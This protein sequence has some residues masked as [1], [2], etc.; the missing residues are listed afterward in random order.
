MAAATSMTFRVFVSSTF[1]DLL[2]ERNALQNDALKRLRT[3]CEQHGGRFSPVDLRW[4]VS[5]EAGQDQR[6]MSICL[7]EI[8]RCQQATPRPNFIILLGQRYGWR[9]L[10]AA[11]SVEDVER[12]RTTDALEKGRALFDRLYSAIDLNAVPN[13]H[14]LRPRT[15]DIE[16]EWAQIEEDVLHILEETGKELEWPF[17]KRVLYG[18]SATEQEIACGLLRDELQRTAREH[19]HAFFINA[20]K[21]ARDPR[22]STATEDVRPAGADLR[23]GALKQRLRDTLGTNVHEYERT[24]SDGGG[25]EHLARLCDDVYA[26]LAGTIRIEA[27]RLGRYDLLEREIEMHQRFALERSQIFIGRSD[28]LSRVDSSLKDGN[29]H[30]FALIGPSGSGKSAVMAKAFTNAQRAYGADAVVVARFIGFTAESASGVALL[31]SLSRHIARE[32]AAPAP[33]AYAE[34]PRMSAVFRDSLKLASSDRPLIIF[35]DALDQLPTSDAARNLSWLPL[36]TLPEHVHVVVSASSDSPGPARLLEEKCSES[37]RAR[38]QPMPIEEAGDLLTLWLADAHRDLQSRQRTALMSAF[39]VSGL[40]LY[41]RFAFEQCRLWRSFDEPQLLA[42][43][44]LAII[45]ALFARLGDPVNHGHMLVRRSLGYL[46]AAKEGLTEDEMV[47]VLSADSCVMGDFKTRFPKSPQVNQLPMVVWSR[48]YYDLKPY[49]T[50]RGAKGA[51]V[52]NFFH[53]QMREVATSEYLDPAAKIARH[54]A[55]AQYF[56]SKP[57]AFGGNVYNTRKLSELPYQQRKSGMWDDLE[58]TLCNLSFI[59]AKCAAGLIY[60]LLADYDAATLTPELPDGAK[61]RIAAFAQFV[62]AQAHL[63]STHPHLTFQQALNEPDAAAPAQSA[64]ARADVDKR[65]R[66]R[67]IGK[68]QQTSACVLTLYGHTS[69]VNGCDVSRDGRRIA[70][71]SSD[72]E[73]KIWSTASGKEELSLRGLP[74]SEESCQFSRDGTRV[75]SGTRD[76]QVTMWDAISGNVIWFRK[77]HDRPVPGVRFSQDGERVVS[78]SWDGRLKILDAETG[79]ELVALSGHRGDACW[80]VFSNDR[81]TIISVGGD[82]KLKSWDASS[83]AEL[84]SVDAHES[85][86]MSVRF[87]TDG[88]WIYTVSQDTLV[89]RWDAATFEL[90]A[91]Y[92]GHEAGVWAAA[93]SPDG[94]R[95]VTGAADGS[96]KVWDVESGA[97]LA[98]LREHTNEVWGLAFFADGSRFV[99]AAWDGMVKVWDL[100]TAQRSAADISFSVPSS[101]VS[102]HWGYMIACCCAPDRSTYAAGSND[103]TLRLWEAAT[104]R[105][106]GVFALHRDFIFACAYS[107]DSRWIVS[108][109]WDGALK[110]FDVHERREA[111]SAALPTQIVFCAFTDDGKRVAAC[112]TTELSVWDFEHGVLS[113]CASWKSEE[114]FTGCA[115][116][117][118]G[119]QLVAALKSG[120]FVFWDIATQ[121]AADEFAGHATQIMFS[122]SRDGRWLAGT[123][124]HGEIWV[125]DV[126]KRKELMTLHGHRERVV[127][128]NFSPDGKRL[129]TGSW[130]GTARIYDLDAPEEP[131]VLE[132]HT[133]QLQDVSFTPDGARIL[134]VAVDYTARLWDAQSGRALGELLWPPDSMSTCAFAPD[135]SYVITASCRHAV[136]VWNGETAAPMNLLSGHEEAVR[137]CAFSRADCLVTASADGTVRVWNPRSGQALGIVGKHCAPVAACAFSPDGTWIASAGHDH[138]VK[139]WD[140]TGR[141]LASLEGHDDWVSKVLVVAHGKYIVSCSLDKTVRIWDSANKQLL[142]VLRGHDA[143]IRAVA[144][145]PDGSRIVTGG[146]DGALNV[147]DVARGENAL[148][149]TGHR[150]AICACTFTDVIV[151]ASRDGTLRIW[152]PSTGGTRAELKGHA[153]PVLACAMSPDGRHVVSVSQD[154]FAKI[155]D[156]QTG[157]LR[158][159]YWL[160]AAAL[161]VSWSPLGRRIAVGDVRGNLRLLELE[162]MGH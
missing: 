56:A 11:I 139:L 59:E 83:G 137:A 50:E 124:E 75:V 140:V 54:R 55:L 60:D 85:E 116:M 110:I 18:G 26:A 63:L 12:M 127:A 27:E 103:G 128:C 154:Q 160:G 45:R 123:S 52:L 162:A 38:L 15:V 4:G 126:E 28:V 76:G 145:S 74:I 49:L 112:S 132:G 42:T 40:P 94:T 149:L 159:E 31:D 82:G 66:L 105:A 6:T 81:K 79:D 107:P 61:A 1:A 157:T 96:I 130:D 121:E 129:V 14:C 161:N 153:G 120:R 70:S 91:T 101:D 93:I 111:A 57:D 84:H 68:P 69:Y 73:I 36:G 37:H 146:E 135:G 10:P 72:Q 115:L 30:V 22:G 23:L 7:E 44:V 78:A 47:D 108:G 143:A 87:S 67:W 2:E 51:A 117:P 3:L 131:I 5:V 141:A 125:Y 144:E 20:P 46:R 104:G 113:V 158:S 89:K 8:R 86:I 71:A 24:E 80:A 142:H 109:A 25:A 147:W 151:S 92:E 29:S 150:G 134:S 58:A 95:L 9:P 48:L 133:D 64:A 32:F 90:N 53:R 33:A 43:D 106:L 35:L 148:A 152:D 136:K 138:L 62:R 16:A 102:S 122:L 99:S 98:N 34:Y 100:Q 118:G 17:A 119:R 13:V 77:L 156:V 21:L 155:W 41:L 39:R 19:V 65:P 97:E 88:A 114:A